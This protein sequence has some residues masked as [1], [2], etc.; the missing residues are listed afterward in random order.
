MRKTILPFSLACLLATA[1]ASAKTIKLGTLAPTGSPWH[2]ALLDMA[3]QWSDASEKKVELK[4]YPDGRL[5]NEGDMVRKIRIGQLQGAMITGIGLSEIARAPLALQIPMMFESWEQLD[6]V[7]DAMAPAL[8]QSILEKGFV[9][10]NWGD[11]GWVHQFSKT[12]A[13]TA[14]DYR[15]LKYFVWAGDSES[16]NAWRSAGFNPVPLS[17][18]DVLSSLQTGMISAFGTSAIYAL[19]SQWFGLAKNMVKVKWVA[20][21]GATVVEKKAWEA[22]DPTIQKKL[23]DISRAKGIELR[24]TVRDMNDKA[25]DAMVEKGLTVHVPTETELADWKKAAEIA[26]PTI[27]EKVVDSATFDA[28]QK[29]AAQCKGK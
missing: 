20:L 14:D 25:V 19:S 7:R 10:L 18:T 16:E 1:P 24:K 8:E 2:K 26:Y 21:N 5:G 13:K 17:S 3:Q 9:V 15:K 11:A 28:V 23:L 4:I 27:R 29:L 6:C 22:I 12:P